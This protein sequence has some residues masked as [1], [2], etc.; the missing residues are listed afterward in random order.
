MGF[1]RQIPF[2]ASRKPSFIFWEKVRHRV[3]WKTYFDGV[4]ELGR[5]GFMRRSVGRALLDIDRVNGW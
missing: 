5:L 4:I 3:C 1:L 2:E